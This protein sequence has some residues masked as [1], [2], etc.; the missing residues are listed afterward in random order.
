MAKHIWI[1][2]A[3]L[4]AGGCGER[5]LRLGQRQLAGA[6][7]AAVLCG[8]ALGRLARGWDGGPASA[9]A[10]SFRFSLSAEP[11]IIT[12][13]GISTTSI[14]VQVPGSG[15]A[16][17]AS[18][19]VRFLTTAGSIEPQARVVGG[20][21]RA[22]L[23]SSTTPGTAVVTAIIGAAREQVTVEFSSDEVSLARYLQVDGSYVAYNTTGST[24]T[25]SGKCALDYG[26]LHIESDVRLDVDLL[27]ERLWAQ[28]SSGHVTIR[29]SKSGEVHELRGDRLFYDIARRR[30]VLRRIDTRQGPARQEFMDSDFRALP[31]AQAPL[32]SAQAPLP[33][34]QAPLPP[35]QAPLPI[36]SAAIVPA[37]PLPSTSSAGRVASTSAAITPSLAPGTASAASSQ[38]ASS[39][40]AV[41]A[42]ESGEPQNLVREASTASALPIMPRVEA[43]EAQLNT[44]T[45]ASMSQSPLLSS[46]PAAPDAASSVPSMAAQAAPGKATAGVANTASPASTSSASGPSAREIML[47]SGERPPGSLP[48]VLDG[49]DG[50]PLQEVPAY[51]PLPEAG[52]SPAQGNQ[53]QGSAAA[54]G[55]AE[56]PA[57]G[58]AQPV[59]ARVAEQI[60]EPEPPSAGSYGGYWVTARKIRIFAHDKIQFEKASVFFNGRKL[61]SMPRYVAALNGNF[62]P[63]TDMVAFNSSGG[64]TLNVPYYYQASTHGT[65][66]LYAQYAPHNGF[67]AESPGP[68]LAFDQQYWLNDKSQG[69]L[70]VDQIGHA[71]NLNW[72]HEHQ[73][74]PTMRGALYLDMPRHQNAFLR[75]ALVKDTRSA[76]LGFEGLLARLRDTPGEAQGQFYARLRPRSL[77]HSGWSYSMGANLIALR[78]FALISGGGTGSGGSGNGGT[79]SGGSG[80]GGTGSG[81]SGNGGSGNG[82]AGSGGTGNGGTGNGGT[83]SGNGGGRPGGVGIP[84][85]GPH[86][87]EGGLEGEFDSQV[88]PSAMRALVAMRAAQ[89]G[90]AASTYASS[91]LIGQTLLSTLQSPSARLWRGASL[92]GSVLASAFNYSNGRR[93]LSP[94]LNMN[95]QQALGRVGGLQMNYNFDRGGLSSVGG[96]YGSAGS[97]FASASLFLNLAQRLSANAYFTRSFSDGGTYG[98]ATLDFYP[99][100]RWRMGLF[101]D[102][103][104]FDNIAAYLDY[105]LSLGRQVGQ[106]EVSL[107]WSRNRSRVYLELGGARY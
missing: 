38:A 76:Q 31:P 105:G 32:P 28:G 103:S 77:G 45:Q 6:L 55:G 80:N 70:T 17:S 92:S 74:S 104:R 34:A 39:A 46:R 65:G 8:P 64:L 37:R 52:A 96:L 63:A 49:A 72:N 66:T 101:S 36:E 93:G 22:L 24:I 16:F 14:S 26:D 95:F 84:G 18:P 79:G 60:S 11:D 4:A 40:Q 89:A 5:R 7:G 1:C 82:G 62:S 67:A 58:A 83:G 21:A 19:V 87:L 57:E 54:S 25:A 90:E 12:A 13:N 48:S 9:Q 41:K 81:G 97:N 47:G 23:R 91:T 98:A 3:P 61:F 27:G 71:W 106:R 15:S 85:R 51:A 94:G 86:R 30:G 42:P 68:A 73:F 107:N 99:I 102:Y 69:R 33:P 2:R 50:A 35:A 59:Q 20:V 53:A 29:D 88:R 100:P 10:Q 78:Q 56:A 75:S 43:A 44:R